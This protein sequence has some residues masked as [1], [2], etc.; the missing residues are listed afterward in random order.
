MTETTFILMALVALVVG[1]SHF[2]FSREQSS[3]RP[4]R[5]RRDDRRRRVRR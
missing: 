2:S 1:V 4:V 3:L 5:V